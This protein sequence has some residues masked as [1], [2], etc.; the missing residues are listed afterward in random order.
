MLLNCTRLKH[1]CTTLRVS[2][3]HC[4]GTRI[5][6]NSISIHN[7]LLRQPLLLL[8]RPYHQIFRIRQPAAAAARQLLN[9][10]GSTTFKSA[11]VGSR[12]AAHVQCLRR[13]LTTKKSGALPQHA[14]RVSTPPAKKFR[15]GKT[16]Y[17]RLYGL[18]KTEK[19]V[20]LG[21]QF[22]TY[23]IINQSILTFF[24]SILS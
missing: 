19:W 8:R 10:T 15:M 4:M 22:K 24:N 9:S 14:R 3:I 5:P 16:E 17:K 12:F 23:P 1:V 2:Q 7:E 13:F 20:L 6:I 18:I 11:S 21:M